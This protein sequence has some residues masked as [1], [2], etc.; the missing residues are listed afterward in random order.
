M[1][2]PKLPMDDRQE[3]PV[4][5]KK[6]ERSKSKSKRRSFWEKSFSKK[7][8][9]KPTAVAVIYLRNNGKADT[10]EVE[11]KRGFFEINHKVYH[12]DKDCIYRTKDGTPLAIIPEWSLVPYGTQQWHDKSMLEKFAEL[13]D[14]TIRGIRHAELVKMG[15]KQPSKINGKAI[16]GLILLAVI[17]WA[18]LSGGGII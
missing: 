14:H 9:T 17:G 1:E 13:Q 18:I 7:K 6:E 3:K 15:E 5:E 2:L 10:M 4:L 11:T 16:V 8:L 12:E